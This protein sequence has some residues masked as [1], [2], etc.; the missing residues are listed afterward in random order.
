VRYRRGW[1]HRAEKGGCTIGCSGSGRS[2][3]RMPKSRSSKPES[4]RQTAATRS[5]VLPHRYTGAKGDGLEH[6]VPPLGH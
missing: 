6:S 2:Y 4:A 1:V 3:V 5:G